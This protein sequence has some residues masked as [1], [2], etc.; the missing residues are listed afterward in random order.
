MPEILG[1][2]IPSPLYALAVLACPVGMGVM[3]WF[4][5]RGSRHNQQMGQAPHAHG[6]LVRP[7]D[8]PG[9]QAGPRASRDGPAPGLPG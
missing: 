6:F 8:G 1:L 9:D 2:V 7:D 5:M 4:M 3:M